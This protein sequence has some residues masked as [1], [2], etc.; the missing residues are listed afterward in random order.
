MI[1]GILCCCIAF[2]SIVLFDMLLWSNDLKRFVISKNCKYHVA[3]L[4][5]YST[6]CNKLWFRFT[7]FEIIVTQYWI[8]SISFAGGTNTLQC[9]CMNHSSGYCRASFGQ[10][11]LWYLQIYRIVLPQGQDQSKQRAVLVLKMPKNH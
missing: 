4:V 11:G 1:H 3:D 2:R 9:Q 10:S 7:F 6:H 8:F 5:R